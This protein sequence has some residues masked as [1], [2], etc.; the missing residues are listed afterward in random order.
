M[1][2]SI[3]F[4]TQKGSKSAKTVVFLHGF[5]E[6][7]SIWESISNVLSR[8]YRVLCID[9]LGHGKTPVISSVHTMEM[10]AEEV[11]V[12]L[13][14]EGI[15]MCTL[16]GHSMGGYVSLAFGELFPE[17]IEG[18]VL[19]NSTP[20]PDSEEKKANRDRVLKVIEKEK[21]LFVRTAVNNLVSEENRT[22]IK[23][24]LERLVQIGLCTPNEGIVA[25]S[26]GM[27]E[28]PNRTSVLKSLA[29]KRGFILGKSDA[30]ISYEEMESLAK[31]LAMECEVLSGGHLVYIE[32]ESDTIEVLRNFL[33]S[34]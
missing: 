21:E 10:M 24:A 9:L 17:K 12:V 22:K 20:L 14:D 28:R 11:N 34:L 13:E 31:T 2:R 5:L 8:D 33:Q 1:G 19:L 16:V 30:L 25:A 6:D 7:S 4:Y 32:N 23:S 3:S 29:I 27:K 26:L 15:E 18:L